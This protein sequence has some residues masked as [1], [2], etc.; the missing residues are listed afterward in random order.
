MAHHIDN[1]YSLDDYRTKPK[2]TI[3]AI[4][5]KVKAKKKRRT[6]I[7]KA[8]PLALFVSSTLLVAFAARGVRDVSAVSYQAV[9]VG[10]IRNNNLLDGLIIRE[11]IVYASPVTGDFVPFIEEGQ[12]IK[13]DALIGAV[14]NEY[15]ITNFNTQLQP[16]DSNIS[17]R[18]PTAALS[19]QLTATD[20]SSAIDLYNQ[21]HDSLLKEDV[22]LLR[23]TLDRMLQNKNTTYESAHNATEA[24]YQSQAIQTIADMGENAVQILSPTVGVVS[25]QIDGYENIEKRIKYMEFNDLVYN[26]PT[27]NEAKIIP[28]VS[29]GYPLLK[30]IPD[31]TFHIVTFINKAT[32]SDYFVGAEYKLNIQDQDTVKGRLIEK[33]TEDDMTRL[34]FELDDSLVELL[35][36]RKIKFTIGK[37]EVAGLKIP[38]DS[39]VEKSVIRI[40]T[41]YIATSVDKYGKK[42]YGVNKLVGNKVVFAPATIQSRDAQTATIFL[43]ELAKDQSFKLYDIIVDGNSSIT[44]DKVETI[45]GVYVINQG[46]ANFKQIEIAIANEE[47]AI[48]SNSDLTELKP[49]DQIISNPKGIEENDLV[50]DFNLQNN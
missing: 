19:K 45:K 14:S 50:R 2:E 29:K 10:A 8:I 13:K 39:V 47:Y 46:Y 1:T 5:Y 31:Y 42:I 25:Y 18:P 16:V 43:P 12:K 40:P 49:E 38:L 34:I 7:A 30:I 4:T 26:I 27:K 23:S 11:E 48:L 22:Y 6:H 20:F 41:S 36:D 17:Y 28:D 32:S 24:D 33:I 15:M 37:T 35:G 21:T 9:S 3:T 44:L